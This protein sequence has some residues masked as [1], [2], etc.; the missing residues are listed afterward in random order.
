MAPQPIQRNIIRRRTR[1]S[2]PTSSSSSSRSWRSFSGGAKRP[3][4]REVLATTHLNKASDHRAGT[5][6]L[7]ETYLPWVPRPHQDHLLA[8]EESANDSED[9]IRDD[10]SGEQRKHIVPHAIG[11]IN[12]ADQN[13]QHEDRDVH[14]DQRHDHVRQAEGTNAERIDVFEDGRV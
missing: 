12:G 11:T 8:T 9:D 4:S 2:C 10:K 6:A 1:A 14:Q 13:Q 5:A 3:S 7:F